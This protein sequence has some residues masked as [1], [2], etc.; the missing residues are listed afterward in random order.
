MDSK[1]LD[2]ARVCFTYRIKMK[3]RVKWNT[4]STFRQN[5]NCRC[6]NKTDEETQEH[7]EICKGTEVKNYLVKQPH[8]VQ[9]K[10]NKKS[11]RHNE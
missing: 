4:S 3:I 7:L 5:M 8:G 9:K 1:K 11:K 2:D 10:V 6:C